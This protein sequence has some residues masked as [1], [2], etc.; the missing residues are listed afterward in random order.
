MGVNV[1][2]WLGMALIVG[3]IALVSLPAAFVA[4]GLAVLAY[5]VLFLIDF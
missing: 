3:G 5:T 1:C 2:Y 4:A